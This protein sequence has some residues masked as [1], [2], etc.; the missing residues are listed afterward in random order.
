MMTHTNSK[1]A[2]VGVAYQAANGSFDAQAQAQLELEEYID[3]QAQDIA[4][5]FEIDA[6]HDSDFGTLYRV[7]SGC[8]LLGTFYR[9]DS[10]GLWVAQPCD[11]DARPRCETAEQAQLLIMAVSGL[12]VADV[13]QP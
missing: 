6:I 10:D 9:A 12:L 13:A 7:W 2:A 4:P 5:E 11:C 1:A 8:K 3:E